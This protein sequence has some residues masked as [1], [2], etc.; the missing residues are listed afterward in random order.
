M[1][2]NIPKEGVYSRLKEWMGSIGNRTFILWSY[3]ED[4]IAMV[5][6]RIN[7]LEGGDQT[8]GTELQLYRLFRFQ[9]SDTWEISQDMGKFHVDVIDGQVG[10]LLGNLR[11]WHNQNGPVEQG[12]QTHHYHVTSP[13]EAA[14][15][16]LEC[17]AEDLTDESVAFN[18]FGLE[19]YDC[20]EW[21]EWIEPEEGHDVT[22]LV[23]AARDAEGDCQ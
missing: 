6:V 13:E 5:L 23:D 15:V 21:C 12:G 9:G 18:A 10:N 17:A 4:N 22:A 7:P 16:I 2:R 3:I 19:E 1:N 11:V 14:K 20:G 8:M